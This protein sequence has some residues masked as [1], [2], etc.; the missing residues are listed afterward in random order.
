MASELSTLS[1]YY[2]RKTAHDMDY[3][4]YMGKQAMVKDI[5][6]EI[7]RSTDQQMI[8]TAMTGIKISDR[9]DQSAERI[10]HSMVRMQT[11]IQTS[12]KAQTLAIVA[13]QA[14][15]AYTFN[16][17]FDK[18]NNTLD[19]GFSGIS[20]Q[21]G[22]MTA[23]FSMGF[24]SIEKAI[25]KMSKE[26]CDRLDALHDIM[27]NPLLT[28]SRE[29]YRRAVTNYNKGF[30]EE[31]LE[32][33]KS[34]VE[35]NKT[36]YISWFHFG[37]IYLFGVSEFSNVIDLEKAVENFVTA[38]KYNKPDITESADARRMAAEIY[39]YLGLASYS[40]SNDLLRE[41]KGTEAAEML[42]KARKS[43]EQSYQ[44]SANMLESLFN[45]ARCKVIQGEI[46]GAINDLE[47][48]VLKERNYCI[49]VFTDD[50]FSGINEQFSNLIMKLKK[51]VF[52]NAKEKFDQ[53]QTLLSELTSIGGTIQE[54][55]PSTFSEELPYFDILDYEV[56]FRGIIPILQ[57]AIEKRKKFLADEAEYNEAKEK[58]L[59]IYNISK[60]GEVLYAFY[61]GLEEL[62]HDHQGDVNEWWKPY[63]DK[64]KYGVILQKKM[65]DKISD[66]KKVWERLVRENKPL[67]DELAVLVEENYKADTERRLEKT[68]SYERKFGLFV[69]L[70]ILVDIAG[71]VLSVK[72]SNFIIAILGFILGCAIIFFS[73][74][75][76]YR[77]LGCAG[78][79]VLA[80]CLHLIVAS[81]IAGFGFHSFLLGLFGVIISIVLAVVS[82]K[83][84]D[85][86][87]IK[88]VWEG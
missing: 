42:M 68:K 31:A 56:K 87:D 28:Q 79:G 67:F 19:M 36:D 71:I 14:A 50:D 82:W 43:F 13:S 22:E 77:D 27:N 63:W 88:T 62:L 70:S 81:F 86:K 52:V 58:L 55:I 12:I 53:I 80:G 18:I 57:T 33:I 3:R 35:K 30:F 23:S 74:K 44:Y 46:D 34:A 49:K 16:K 78:G 10:E 5:G 54:N 25:E 24:F 85:K 38:A 21:L 69:A 2:D 4:E 26:I 48:L 9:I 60:K 72:Q 39:F 65:R 41:K 73:H 64:D 61:R 84:Y 59:E 8:M 51:A 37:K 17:G 40:K 29:L 75:S 7:Q 20:N 83:V 66:N 47:T 15:L 1:G 6:T 76:Y 45:T 11:G 32:D